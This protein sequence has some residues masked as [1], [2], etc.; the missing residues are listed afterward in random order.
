MDNG[1]DNGMPPPPGG[2][3]SAP[4][5][6]GFSDDNSASVAYIMPEGLAAV[7]L[8]V[9]IFFAVASL[10]VVTLR[11]WI[12]A[13]G[14]ILGWDDG[15][16]GFG[17]LLFLTSA[18][19]AS[20][21]TFQGL[22]TPNAGVGSS[23]KVFGLKVRGSKSFSRSASKTESQYVMI[24]Q[25]FYITSLCFIKNSICITMLRI[26]IKKA[27]RW[28]LYIT[29][30]LS[31]AVSLVGFIGM[32]TVC[33][34][35]TAQWQAG[36]G[37]CAPRSTI[38]VLNYVI[39]AGAI[40]T[41]WACAIIPAFILWNTQMKRNVKLS[42]GIVLGLGSLASIS[43]FIRIPYLRYYDDSDNFLCRL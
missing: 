23:M 36:S 38:I 29:I 35:I 12:R 22:G 16:M 43:T 17:L 37:T 34:P 24:W 10:V 9:S 42:V 32:L 27:H 18:G 26:A 11:L 31:T 5:D 8:A 1:M 7:V 3:G 13:R 15:L 14:N 6:A 28:S 19:L 21:A 33:R 2:N 20:Y 30:T 39:S 41:D 25:L 40:V 4:G